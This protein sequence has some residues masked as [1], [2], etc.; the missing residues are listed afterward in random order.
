MKYPSGNL[1]TV[2]PFSA[3][4]PISLLEIMVELDIKNIILTLELSPTHTIIP[5][6][7]NQYFL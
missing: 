2:L 5:F 7:F 1:K 4:K 3:Q 6:G